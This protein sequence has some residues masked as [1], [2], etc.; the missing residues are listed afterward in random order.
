MPI[1]DD[2]ER[3]ILGGSLL[4][5]ACSLGLMAAGLGILALEHMVAAAN[6]CGPIAGHCFLCIGALAS[7]AGALIAGLAGVAQWSAFRAGRIAR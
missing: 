1:I 6:L 3:K 5:L 7:A 2:L 4:V